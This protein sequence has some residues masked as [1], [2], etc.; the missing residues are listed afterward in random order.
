MK[1]RLSLL[2]GLVL[3]AS[4]CGG[5]SVGG[6]SS[7]T[8]SGP[9][10]ESNVTRQSRNAL[11]YAAV[12]RQLVTKDHGFG[13]G[14]SPYRRVYVLDGAVP[15]AANVMRLVDQARKPFGVGVRRQI[16]ANLKRLPPVA[17]IEARGAVIAGSAPG[18]VVHRGVLVTLGPIRWVND[19]TALVANNRWA[20]GLNG[21]WLTYNVKLG[22]SGWKVAGVVGG[23]AI[24]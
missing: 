17:F 1:L 14:P 8:G 15:G 12:I 11:V 22:D 23:V 24:S 6:S 5:G 20:T 13:G 21:Q 16:T 9:S 18:H 2:V 4:A 7:P 10:P 3:G 19:H